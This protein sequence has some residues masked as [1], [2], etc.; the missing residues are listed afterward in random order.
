MQFQSKG[1]RYE[2]KAQ[3]IKHWIFNRE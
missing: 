1:T 3:S 2:T